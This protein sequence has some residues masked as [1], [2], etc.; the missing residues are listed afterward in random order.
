[1]PAFLA[2]PAFHGAAPE[3]FHDDREVFIDL[4][5]DPLRFVDEFLALVAVP[6]EDPW[7]R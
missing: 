7:P 6:A 1:M 3:F 2:G 5:E 4:L